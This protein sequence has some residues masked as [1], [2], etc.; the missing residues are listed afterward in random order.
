MTFYRNTCQ[1]GPFVKS[2]R[3]VYPGISS[4]KL[5]ALYLND[6][7]PEN[8]KDKALSL[9]HMMSGWMTLMNIPN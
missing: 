6:Q 8:I 3:R 2:Y 4:V 5:F 1:L 9:Y 7:Y